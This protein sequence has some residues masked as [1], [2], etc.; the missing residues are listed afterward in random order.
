MKR[1]ILASV[2]NHN[3]S[4]SSIS[5]I[6]SAYV[7]CDLSSNPVIKKKNYVKFVTYNNPSVVCISSVICKMLHKNEIYSIHFNS[8]HYKFPC[9]K[10]KSDIFSK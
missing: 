8:N 5:G 2:S 9:H 6:Q 3:F 10:K 4:I 1:G 7:L